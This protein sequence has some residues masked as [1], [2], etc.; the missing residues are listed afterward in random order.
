M[1]TPKDQSL[2]P[3]HFEKNPILLSAA[4]AENVLFDR[5]ES[6]DFFPNGHAIGPKYPLDYCEVSRTLL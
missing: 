4:V 2:P 1:L 6:F 3:T 5:K